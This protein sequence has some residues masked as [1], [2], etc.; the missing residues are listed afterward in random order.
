MTGCRHSLQCHT[1]SSWHLYLTQPWAIASSWLRATWPH[2]EHSTGPTLIRTLGRFF[3]GVRM[4]EAALLGRLLVVRMCCVSSVDPSPLP[5]LVPVILTG[6]PTG[7]C[8]VVGVAAGGHGMV[9]P[10]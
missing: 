10:L 1:G 3:T 6:V 2:S 7:L 4:P 9:D 5:G 8:Q